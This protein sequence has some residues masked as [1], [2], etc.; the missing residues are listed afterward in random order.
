MSGTPAAG[1][2]PVPGAGPSARGFRWP[3]G[4]RAA[5][6][7]TFDLDAESGILFE[8]PEA[9]GWL[10][11]LSHQAYGP[12]TGVYRLLGVLARQDVRATF[13]VPGW[14][15]ERWPD[16]VR[17]IR[18]DGHEIGHHGYFHEGSRGVTA[19]ELERR[20]LRGFEALD[21]VAGVRPIG[22]RAPMWELSAEMPA[23]LARHGFRYESSLMDSDVPYLLDCGE[24]SGGSPGSGNASLVELPVQW[25]LDDWEAYAYLPGITGSGWI[26]RPSE[27][28]DRWTDEL[29]SL[30]AEGGLFVLT[31]HP[32]LSGRA[33]RAAALETL[34]THAKLSQGLWVATCSEIAT[35]VETLE[36][37][38]YAPKP[39]ELPRSG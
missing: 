37:Q 17:A 34:I 30:I 32:F 35:H 38:P 27:M 3:E 5:A 28:F 31:N 21:A 12:R 10:D 26:A 6:C 14:V 16:A 4:V 33:S 39:V 22:Y 19:P 1:G 20:L 24:G 18:D 7:F 11:V 23:I 2:A 36:L 25:A 13:F 29:D 8:H 9:A 15:A